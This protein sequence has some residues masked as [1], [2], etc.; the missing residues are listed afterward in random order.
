MLLAAA[1]SAPTLFS[2]WSSVL[3][4]IGVLIF[5]LEITFGRPGNNALALV[6]LT[7]VVLAIVPYLLF[8]DINRTVRYKEVSTPD[9]S[10]V[11][12]TNRMIAP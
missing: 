9:K 8:G 3:L 6:P 4:V 7:A 10:R 12:M 11:Q 2:I 1:I 5:V